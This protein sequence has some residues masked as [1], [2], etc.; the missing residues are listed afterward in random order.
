MIRFFD[1]PGLFISHLARGFVGCAVRT[2]LRTTVRTAHPTTDYKD[3]NSLRIP[4][5]RTDPISMVCTAL[6][7]SGCALATHKLMDNPGSNQAPGFRV[8]P[9]MTNVQGSFI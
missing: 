1:Q 2:H 4:A 6:C 7:P 5:V 9:G 8:K 3:R